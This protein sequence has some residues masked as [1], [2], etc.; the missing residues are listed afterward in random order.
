MRGFHSFANVMT[1]LIS[2]RL[3]ERVAYEIHVVRNLAKLTTVRDFDY[4]GIVEEM[5][6]LQPPDFPKPTRQYQPGKWRAERYRTACTRSGMIPPC[7]GRN[8][9]DVSERHFVAG[10]LD[11]DLIRHSS[12]KK[13]AAT[14][15]PGQREFGGVRRSTTAQSGSFGV[16]RALLR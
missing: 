2:E 11:R 16:C 13:S 5:P 1:R 9:A 4:L 3:P 10:V 15:F 12:S 8:V 14:T 6:A 7:L